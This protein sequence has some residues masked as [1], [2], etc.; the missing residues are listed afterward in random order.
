MATIAALEGAI[1]ARLEAKVPGPPV[2]PYPNDPKLYKMFDPKWEL[3]VAYRGGTFE[4]SRNTSLVVQDRTLVFEISV[5]VRDLVGH[6]GGY[7]LLEAV[8]L[9]LQGWKPFPD[10][11][12]FQIRSDDFLNV[13]TGQWY[14][15]VFVATKTQALP[16]PV[17]STDAPFSQISFQTPDGKVRF[18]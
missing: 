14:W 17:P 7:A 4:A 2:K 18:P 11:Q 3:L 12:P 5:L 8:R 10:C 9:A 16:E 1:R 6:Q 13:D 15:A